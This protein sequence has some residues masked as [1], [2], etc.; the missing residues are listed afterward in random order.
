MGVHYNGG[1]EM[2]CRWCGNKCDPRW[3]QPGYVNEHVECRPE[4]VVE[5][6]RLMA[7]FAA[8]A[9]G[10]EWDVVGA[11]ERARLMASLAFV[12]AY[13]GF[14]CSIGGRISIGA[15][16]EREFD[17]FVARPRYQMRVERAA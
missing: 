5:P 9:D 11:G 12:P 13:A 7:G 15:Q 3:G 1:L 6:E 14:D 8:D 2:K 16:G 17:E 4:P 10:L